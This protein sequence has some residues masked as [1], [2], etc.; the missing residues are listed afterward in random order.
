MG[1]E[2]LASRDESIKKIGEFINE[3]DF[4]MMTT[5]DEDGELHSRQ[6]DITF[7]LARIAKQLGWVLEYS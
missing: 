6:A 1:Q 5:I 7:R 3:I 2:K 4:T